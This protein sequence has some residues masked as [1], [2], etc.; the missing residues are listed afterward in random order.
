MPDELASLVTAFVR[1]RELVPLAELHTLRRAVRVSA[2]GKAVAEVVHD[3]VQ[4][5]E[6]GHFV[7]SFSEV[8]IE[9]LE[10]GSEATS[11]GSSATCS[12]SGARPGDGRP[13]VF[14]AL[15]LPAPGTEPVKRGAPAIDHFAEYL[16]AQLDALVMGDPMTRRGDIEGVHGMRVATRRM[17]SALK[18][19]KKLLDPGWVV[20]TRDELRWL[21]G[22]LGE[23]RDYDVFSHYVHKQV[24]DLGA[25]P[26]R[27]GRSS[28][29]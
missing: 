19:G 15:D 5:H 28:S 13:K 12:S 23:V 2:D 20:E 26:R 21:G 29:G 24:A 1:G 6:D 11:S 4:V 10:D 8:E 22:V 18:E 25:D 27:A 9:Q 7:R 16:Q 14:Q 17:R 3:I